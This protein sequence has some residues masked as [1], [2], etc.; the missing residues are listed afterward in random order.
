MSVKKEFMMQRDGKQFVLY[1]GLLDEAHTQGLQSIATT[2]VQIPTEENGKVAICA[3]TVVT[4][5]GT[6]SGIGD[7]NPGNVARPMIPA[8]IRMAETR[9]KARA[10][11]DAVNVG[12][13][14]L[15]E[16]G[17]DEPEQT[18]HAK[19]TK[20]DVTEAA[21][22]GEQ[23]HKRRDM[24]FALQ[25]IARKKDPGGWAK[26]FKWWK[27]QGYEGKPETAPLA[28][29]EAAYRKLTEKT[30]KKDA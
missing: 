8:I 27:E 7:A 4:E 18:T 19:F 22:F 17:D 5:R 26:L 21:E 15:E 6:Y 23:E 14:A 1:A 20:A 11:R 10:L 3:A 29:L 9:A 28:T 13:A 12:V 25:E 30:E 16:L 24:V 2:L